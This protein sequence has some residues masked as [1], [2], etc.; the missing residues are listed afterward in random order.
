MAESTPLHSRLHTEFFFSDDQRDDSIRQR[1][2]A[3]ALIP[4][5][6]GQVHSGGGCRVAKAWAT[7]FVPRGRASPRPRAPSETRGGDKEQDPLGI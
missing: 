7:A 1:T 2:A 5:G 6:P 3:R 4:A